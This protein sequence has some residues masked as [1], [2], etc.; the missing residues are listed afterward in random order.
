[1]AFISLF[2][3]KTK[4]DEAQNFVLFLKRILPETRAFTGS[5]RVTAAT[6][7]EE[8]FMV[9]VEWAELDALEHYLNWRKERGDFSKLLAFLEQEPK[10]TTYQKLDDI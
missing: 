4:P 10:I 5:L 6:L 3:F 9:S 1:M 8:Q 7:G 2:E